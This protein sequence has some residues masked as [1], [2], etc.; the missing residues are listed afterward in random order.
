MR[1]PP[2]G[3]LRD[4]V[5]I[6]KQSTTQGPYGGKVETWTKIKSRRCRIQ[7]INGTEYFSSQGERNHA[8]VRIRFR[9]ETGLLKTAYRLVDQRVSPNRI[10]DIESII[11]P[12]NEHRELICMC[13]ERT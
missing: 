8:T 7:P 1:A 4:R 2:A 5:A 13:R 3:S 11:D 6:Q 10:F 9:Y 12:N